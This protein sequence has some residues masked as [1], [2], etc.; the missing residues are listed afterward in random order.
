MPELA[1]TAGYPIAAI[2]TC[3]QLKRTHL[4]IMEVWE[5]LFQVMLHSY[6]EEADYDPI[7]E[8]VKQQLSLDYTPHYFVAI[9]STLRMSHASEFKHFQ[10]FLEKKSSNSEN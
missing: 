1:K 3:S 2:Q 9:I 4:F 10:E 5:A 8:R 6:L 7:A